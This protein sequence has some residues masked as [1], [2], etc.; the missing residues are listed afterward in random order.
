[1]GASWLCRQAPLRLYMLI[2]G[3]RSWRMAEAFVTRIN[4]LDY[5][6]QDKRVDGDPEP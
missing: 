3:D 4:Q 6:G 2:L 5:C 1:M